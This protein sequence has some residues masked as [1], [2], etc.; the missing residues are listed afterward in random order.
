MVRYLRKVL[1]ILNLKHTSKLMGFSGL[2]IMPGGSEG[3]SFFKAGEPFSYL[4][5]PKADF[6]HVGLFDP[7]DVPKPTMETFTKDMDRFPLIALQVPCPSGQSLLSG[8]E[9]LRFLPVFLSFAIGRF[10]R[11][12]L[13]GR[14]QVH[15]E[16]SIP[17]TAET[18][19]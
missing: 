16:F 7:G 3:P 1:I 8:F 4:L 11:G 12:R 19:M 15:S 9:T 10:S 5:D 6:L 13:L 2:Y 14:D 18:S 17:S